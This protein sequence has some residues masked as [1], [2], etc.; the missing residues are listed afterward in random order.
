[1]LRTAGTNSRW[2][3]RS[4]LDRAIQCR[5]RRTNDWSQNRYTTS[6]AS[7]QPKP[8]IGAKSETPIISSSSK[9]TST[10]TANILYGIL[11]TA[12]TSGVVYLFFSRDS[13]HG[14]P[15]KLV[16]T[17]EVGYD[18]K[19]KVHPALDLNAA[20]AKLRREE[21]SKNCL[22]NDENDVTR[23]DAVRVASNCPVEDEMT[24]EEVSITPKTNL[25][26]WG[27]YDGHA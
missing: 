4:H 23:W 20:S 9:K 17:G 16:S 24:H 14:S 22:G 27:V 12:I 13:E 6:R 7:N 3:A 11:A 2:L 25:Q 26:F 21:R 5:L 18:W 19:G 10:L 8:G 1:M 15:P